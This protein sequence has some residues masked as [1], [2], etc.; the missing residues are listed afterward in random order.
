MMMASNTTGKR[1]KDVAT[2]SGRPAARSMKRAYEELPPNPA[3]NA[4]QKL[5]LR[6]EDEVLFK[7]QELAR[8]EDRD[9]TTGDPWRVLRITS[10]FVEGFDTLAHLDPAVAIFGSARVTP[11]SPQYQAATDVARRLA[12]AGFAIITGGGPGIM[13]AAN[14]GAVEGGGESVGC[15]IELP[16]EQGTNEYVEIAVNFRYFFV[17]KTMFLKYSEACW[18]LL[19]RAATPR[20]RS[21]A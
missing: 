2:R 11:D 20:R 9:F 5:G 21:A 13:E 15:N 7:R 10:E 17:R 19:L 16:F 14:K 12:R 1:S 6:T 8:R 3:L 18:R 4:A